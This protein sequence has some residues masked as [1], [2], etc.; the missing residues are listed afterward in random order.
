MVQ[1]NARQG[2]TCN[3]GERC[4]GIIAGGTIGMSLRMEGGL[5]FSS[6]VVRQILLTQ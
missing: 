6:G 4:W 2:D 1:E 5:R 3:G